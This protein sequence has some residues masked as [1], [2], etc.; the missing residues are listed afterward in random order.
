MYVK[1]QQLVLEQLIHASAAT[2]IFSTFKPKIKYYKCIPLLGGQF[3]YSP[4]GVHKTTPRGRH[5]WEK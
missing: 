2:A 5:R 4:T 3:E 1:G